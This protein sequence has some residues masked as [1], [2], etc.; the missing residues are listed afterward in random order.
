M[1]GASV[2]AQVTIHNTHQC[3]MQDEMV[4]GKETIFFLGAI[5]DITRVISYVLISVVFLHF[6][7]KRNY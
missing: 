5:L 1:D 4:C 7:K 3:T 6:P 2:G